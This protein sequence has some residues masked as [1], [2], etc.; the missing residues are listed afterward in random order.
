MSGSFN[1][2]REV[3]TLEDRDHDGCGRRSEKVGA[4]SGRLPDSGRATRGRRQA[5]PLA[6]LSLQLQTFGNLFQDISLPHPRVSPL[7]SP[8]PLAFP[9][10]SFLYPPPLLSLPMRGTVPLTPFTPQ[11]MISFKIHTTFGFPF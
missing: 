3:G 9:L 1:G 8:P 5:D 7:P 11:S 2:L 4:R 6:S 10:F